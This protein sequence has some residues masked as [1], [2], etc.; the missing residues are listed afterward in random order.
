MLENMFR[1]S[2]LGK[3]LS[4]LLKYS[5]TFCEPI[6][7]SVFI[8]YLS[9]FHFLLGRMYLSFILGLVA[10]TV[11]LISLR[12][13]APHH[14]RLLEGDVELGRQYFEE[15]VHTV[16]LID[17][18][19]IYGQVGFGCEGAGTTLTGLLVQAV[20]F[21]VLDQHNNCLLY[22]SPSPRDLS[23]SRMPSSA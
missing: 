9:M 2:C 10:K 12:P 15:Q 23:T 11:E 14:D 8:W 19:N 3:I 5:W 1:A 18:R 17:V 22:T 16:G 6:W 21:L 13:Y 20:L 4:L 7:L